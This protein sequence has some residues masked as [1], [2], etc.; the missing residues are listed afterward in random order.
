M[1]VASQQQIYQPNY[2]AQLRSASTKRIHSLSWGSKAAQSAITE[3]TWSCHTFPDFMNGFMELVW[4][5]FVLA[6]LL[7]LRTCCYSWPHLTEY[8][9]SWVLL[10]RTRKPPSLQPLQTPLPPKTCTLPLRIQPSGSW[11]VI[12]ATVPLQDQRCVLTDSSNWHCYSASCMYSSDGIM[13]Q[14]PDTRL[15]VY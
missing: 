7:Q 5:G 1:V 8:T 9:S 11:F 14:C 13:A 2:S 4:N 15:T 3:R 12:D 10:S 6:V